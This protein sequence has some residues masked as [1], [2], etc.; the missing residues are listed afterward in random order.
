MKEVLKLCGV[1]VS[2]KKKDIVFELVYGPNENGKFEKIPY[3]IVTAEQ[4]EIPKELIF[5][6][7]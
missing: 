1:V 4:A 5:P 7:K 2:D 6:I 3:D